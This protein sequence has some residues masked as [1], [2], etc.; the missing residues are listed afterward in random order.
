M[1]KSIV[2]FKTD[3]R[4]HDNET[5]H[6]AIINSDEILPVYC[7]DEKQFEVTKFGFKKTGNY[8]AQFLLE[9][10]ADLDNELRKLGSGLLI[11]KGKVTDEL[12]QIAKSYSA[13][14]IYAKKEIAYEEKLLEVEVENKLG[15]LN[16]SLE[17]IGT[18]TLYLSKDLPF[19]IKDIPPVFT[20]FRKKV[21]KVSQVKTTFPMPKNITSPKIVSLNLPALS[22]LGLSLPINDIRKV[23]DFK[24][25]ENEGLKRLHYYFS[26]TQLISKYKETRNGLIGGDYSSKFSPW[27]ALGCLSP[28]E[29]YFQIKKFE[30][31]FVANKSTYWLFFELLWRDYFK[32]MMEKYPHQ[33]FLYSGIKEH[34]KI[35]PIQKNNLIKWI[36]GE[37]GVDFVDAN[38]KELKQT[39]FMSN[40]GRQ[41]VA[42]YLVND[43]E[44]DWRYGASYF[45]QQ[46]IDYDVSSNWGN[47]A[48]IAGVGNDPRSNRYFNIE[49]QAMQYDPNQDYIRLWL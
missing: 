30:T 14:K 5:L 45:E 4:I 28:R 1:K 9:S 27:M 26:Q 13:S 44:L 42:S 31:E 22:E 15:Q 48:Y 37:T 40:R 49:K 39:G 38:M 33:F 3:L 23:L 24:G 6:E 17:T 43:L 20:D 18:S 2:W 32:F 36:N 16:C 7:F 29:I 12:Y 25:G 10:L 41:N 34:V 19:P 47:W 46:L 35:K 11:L 21:E 8:R